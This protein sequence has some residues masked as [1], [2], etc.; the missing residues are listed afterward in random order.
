MPSLAE[1]ARRAGLSAFHFHR[2]FKAVTGVTPKAY[3]AAHRAKRVRAEL[4]PQRHG[5]RGDLRRRL[6]L[7]R[8]VLRERRMQVLGMTPTDYRARRREHRRSV[9][10]SANARSARS[11]S[12]RA[13]AASVRILLGD[14][15]DALVRDLQDRFP[16]AD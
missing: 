16:R 7:E 3:A 12:P 13:S 8:A 10:P 6:Q 1:L 2:V 9:S 4:R 5:D 11:W 15:P 14:D